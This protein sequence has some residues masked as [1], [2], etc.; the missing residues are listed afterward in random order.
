MNENYLDDK[1]RQEDEFLKDMEYSLREKKLF[2]L[3]GLPYSGKSTLRRIIMDKNPG[4]VLISADQIRYQI[5][6]Q[7]YRQETEALMWAIRNHFLEILFQNANYIIIDETNTTIKRRSPIIRLAKQYEYKVYC[8]Y[9]DIDK[10]I[11]INRIKERN[12]IKMMSV[13]D[14]QIEQFEV[15]TMDEGF[16][17][18]YTITGNSYKFLNKVNIFEFNNK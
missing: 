10:D 12:D 4:I 9:L 13:I 15:P 8:F 3:C 7:R 6:G 17:E 2:M 11:C 18:I 16:K 14:R 1:E 5:Y